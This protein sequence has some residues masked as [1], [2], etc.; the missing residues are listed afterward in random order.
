MDVSER[1]LIIESACAVLERVGMRMPGA[2]TVGALRERGALVD[3]DTDTVR[4]PEEMVRAALASLPDELLIAGA[5]PAQDVVLDRRSGPFFNPAGCMAKTLDHRTG[6]L[7]PSDLRDLREG[8][9]VMDATPEIDVMW[10]FVSANDV[11]MER[12]ELVEY[13]T[14]L[15]NT[16]KPLV[17]VDCPT[18]VDAV[19]RIMEILGDGLDGYRR[20]PRL[21]VL[22][23]ARAPL[24]VN[25]PLLDTTCELAALGSPVWIYTMPISGATSPITM[26]G[27]LALMWAEVLG[28]TIAVQAVAPGAAVLACC[29]PGVLDMRTSSMSLGCPENTVL[30]AASVEIGHHLG[31]PVHNPGQATDAKHPGLQAG[32]EKG[33]KALAA[34][35]AGADL[36]SAGFGALSASSIFHLPMV[37]VDAEIARLVKRIVAGAEVTAET[38]MLEAIER[39]GPGGNYLKERITR[40]R[41]RAGEHFTPAIGSRLPF[42]RWLAE[43]R[44]E[45]D[46][47]RDR[48]DRL[49]AEAESGTCV[50]E[51]GASQLRTDQLKALAEV[52]GVRA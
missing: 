24:E 46:E 45:S 11:P 38:V 9:L 3:R 36:I 32:Y 26:G 21:G 34:A 49:L 40:E 50:R 23:A 20:R 33:T 17:C 42:E 19:R 52:C 2:R 28:L 44:L 22:C 47:A 39:V 35:L 31:L 13:Y 48:V 4:M 15:A 7:R 5:T 43:G 12:R 18:E 37:A 29:G 8:T 25:G 30:A 14:Y 41:V 16:A 10:T 1:D 27:T 51:G 6:V